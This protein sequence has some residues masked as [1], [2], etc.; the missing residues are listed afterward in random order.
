MHGRVRWK[1]HGWGELLSRMLIQQ[2]VLKL[3]DKPAMASASHRVRG[4]V[5]RLHREDGVESV[6]GVVRADICMLMPVEEV[7][8]VAQRFPAF[9]GV[10]EF[11]NCGANVSGTKNRSVSEKGLWCTACLPEVGQMWVG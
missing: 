11:S 3:L 6:L 2:H 4:V 8:L 10:R 9:Q 7:D 5:S 1:V